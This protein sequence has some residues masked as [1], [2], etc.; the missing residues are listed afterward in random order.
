MAASEISRFVF[1]F[2]QY[3]NHLNTEHL[4]TRFI[5]IPDSMGVRY[6]NVLVDHS[7]TG[8]FGLQTGFFSQFQDHHL[9]TGDHLTTGH[10]STI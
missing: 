9:N 7:N 6:S 5:Y 8:H 10:K 3:S 1:G 4:N 2:C